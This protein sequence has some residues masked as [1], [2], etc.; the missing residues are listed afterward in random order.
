[1]KTN[2][3]QAKDDVLNCY[4]DFLKI[5]QQ[6]NIV[7]VADSSMVAL[8][9]QAKKIEEDRFT[10][11]VAGEAKSGKSTFI[12][13]YLG[14]EILPMGVLQC[15]SSI[16]EIRYG[17]EFML[18]AT[19]ADGRKTRIKGVDSIKAFLE[20]NAAIDNNYREIPVTLIN[21]E[22]IVKYKGK[23]IPN[24]IIEDL[25][26]GVER[27]NIHKLPQNVYNKKIKEYI[28][29]KQACWKSVV[30]KIVITYPF[31]D[32]S[33]RGIRIID[34]PGVNA[35]GRVG[36][37][38]ASYIETA[39]AIMFLRPIIGQAIEANSFKEFLE[40]KSVDRNQN[41]IFLILTRAASENEAA[42]DEAYQ[43]FVKIFGAQKKE[44]SKGIVKEQII[45]VDSKAELYFNVFNRLTTEEID[46]K[47]K[48]LNAEQKSEPF[49]KLA[50]LETGKEKESFL[51]ELKRISRFDMIDQ[52]LNK[53]GRKAS[54]IALSEFLGRMETV[55]NSKIKLMEENIDDWKIKQQDPNEL[56][57]KL[58][59]KKKELTEI[60]NRMGNVA[61]EISQSYNSNR[62]SEDETKKTIKEEAEKVITDYK[63]EIDNIEGNSDKSL[64][65][66]EKISFR[67]IK[68]FHDFQISLQEKVVKECD[69]KLKV[70]LGNGIVDFDIIKPDF[71][72]EMVDKIKIDMK[73][74]AYETQT[75]EDGI[76]FKETKTRSVFSQKKYYNLVKVSIMERIDNI[77]V[78]VISDLRKFVRELVAAYKKE[79][80]NKIDVYKAEKNKIAQAKQDAEEI[81]KIIIKL[82][83]NLNVMQV[84]LKTVK[85]IKGGID[86]NL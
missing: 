66:L 72:K 30:V 17:K 74:Q 38:T 53:F 46:A 14:K 20:K 75:Y 13:A 59:D 6:T 23:R 2:Y 31:E 35:A 78:Q 40:T 83:K 9:E 76:T 50:W 18:E 61:D 4:K 81:E 11:M 26:K 54:F 22:I 33:M 63:I 52:A 47:I 29:E 27:D 80:N 32:K 62:P 19:Y 86:G 15:T 71:T 28:K 70:T 73:D 51:K 25:L 10:L 41:A 16:V 3:K 34:S 67:Q 7:D 58:E 43:E 44:T 8:A 82:Q 55:Y 48:E 21:N 60:E 84:N 39:D 1:M 57:K 69:D 37:M 65:D 79:L 36:D 45:P 49:L 64:D 85:E 77:K 56:A 12:N 68:I 42:I 5:V 24:E